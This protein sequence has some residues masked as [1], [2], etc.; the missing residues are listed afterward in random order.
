M[1]V[2]VGLLFVSQMKGQKVRT[3]ATRG[4]GCIC[5]T[6]NCLCWPKVRAMRSQSEMQSWRK[7]HFWRFQRWKMTTLST[8]GN[9]KQ[10]CTSP[11]GCAGPLLEL[12][13][14]S[15]TIAD[16]ALVAPV[17]FSWFASCCNMNICCRRSFSIRLPTFVFLRYSFV[18][19][20]HLRFINLVS[21][22]S[23]VCATNW[24]LHCSLAYD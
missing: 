7:A 9:N 12:V 15:V 17:L 21:A 18:A 3:P 23:G 14:C 24:K 19:I 13:P 1:L 5:A 2:F 6:V 16:T 20:F 10:W 11:T 22:I 8:N 4:R